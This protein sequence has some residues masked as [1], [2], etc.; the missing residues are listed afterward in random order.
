[1]LGFPSWLGFLNYLFACLGPYQAA[2]VMSHDLGS[3]QPMGDI[4]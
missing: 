2:E 4:T 3:K 1:M